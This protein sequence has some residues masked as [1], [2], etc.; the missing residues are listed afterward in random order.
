[1]SYV[2]DDQDGSEVWVPSHGVGRFFMAM[3]D[4]LADEL[5][6]ATG[7]EKQSE[8]WYRIDS[9]TFAEFIEE[10]VRK[11]WYHSLFSELERGFVAILIVL[12][13]K[14]G[15]PSEAAAYAERLGI[16][17]PLSLEAVRGAMPPHAPH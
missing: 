17:R 9:R 14:I 11:S 5:G 13:E 16:E 2:F 12:L 10:I 15:M 8:D 6:T 3:A 4:Y 7:L 1:V